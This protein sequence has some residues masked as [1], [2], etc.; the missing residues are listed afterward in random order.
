MGFGGFG[1]F[2]KPFKPI[3]KKTK[4]IIRPVTKKV[5]QAV[6]SALNVPTGPSPE[7][8]AAQKKAD[9]QLA[10]QIKKINEQEKKLSDKQQTLASTAS[11]SRRV[12]RRSYRPLLSTARQNA[13]GGIKG[14][15]GKLGG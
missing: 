2:F 12:T 3:I 4:K 14:V 11:R 7:Q 1:G 15:S 9:Q 10:Q 13:A 6:A 5:E 8:I